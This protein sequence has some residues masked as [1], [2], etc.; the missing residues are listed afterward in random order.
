MIEIVTPDTGSDCVGRDNFVTLRRMH[1]GL[2]VHYLIICCCSLNRLLCLS[3]FDFS[4]L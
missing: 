1:C 3:L 4:A 2:H